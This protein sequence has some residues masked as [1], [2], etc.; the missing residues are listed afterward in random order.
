[1]EE[2]DILSDRIAIMNNGWFSAID[3]SL[4]LKN[5]FGEGYTITFLTKICHVGEVV[6]ICKNHIPEMQLVYSKA[7]SVVF[8]ISID[9]LKIINKDI[10]KNFI[11]KFIHKN[12][13]QDFGHPDIYKLSQLVLSV[14][15]TQTSLEQ[16]FNS[17]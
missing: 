15:M 16:V 3:T 2:A 10:N 13:D 11:F 7:G 5:A 14:E 1:M 12:R 6:E 8:T 4:D 9:N 17:L